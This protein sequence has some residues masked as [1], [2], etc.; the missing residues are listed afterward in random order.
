MKNKTSKHKP[1]YNIKKV[2][3]LCIKR[4]FDIVCSIVGI[5]V[6]IPLS[7][8]IK[9]CYVCTGDFHSIFYVQKRIGKN[10]KIFNFYKYRSMVLNADEI[11]EK[12]LLENPEIRKEY[13]KNKKLKHDPR[14]TKIG[15]ILRR[16]SL[17][18]F[19]QFINVLKGDM[20]VIGNR[21]YM[22]REKVDMGKYYDDIVKTKPGIT[23]LWQVSGRND[24]TFKKRLQLEKKYSET[25]SLFLDIRI[26]FHTVIAV[27]TG[28]GAM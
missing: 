20:S 23:G 1:L 15:Y 26:L 2:V 7:V 3:Y 10:G 27:I 11:I 19:P 16:T 12:W 18:E 6:L 8:V 25:C 13:S 14:I 4:L 28:D 24:T 22:L 5:L 9:I 17:D 21:P